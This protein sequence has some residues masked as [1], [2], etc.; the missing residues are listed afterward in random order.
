M[1]SNFDFLFCRYLIH[2]C[3]SEVYGTPKKI[4]M[5]ITM[6]KTFLALLFF[7]TGL[8]VTV[9]HSNKRKDFLECEGVLNG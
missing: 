6:K 8:T 7:P 5:N 4:H 1:L 2:F 9:L 3:G